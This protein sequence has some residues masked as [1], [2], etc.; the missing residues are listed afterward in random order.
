MRP[1]LAC[2]RASRRNCNNYREVQQPAALSL[3]F[4]SLFFLHLTCVDSLHELITS[5]SP[6]RVTLALGLPSDRP[7]SGVHMWMFIL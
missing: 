6:S 3:F 4:P 5:T 2:L 7:S 1:T